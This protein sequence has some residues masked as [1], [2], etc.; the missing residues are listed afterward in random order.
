M[1]CLPFSVFAF[2]VTFHSNFCSLSEA[3]LD[4]VVEPALKETLDM[5]KICL[6]AAEERINATRTKEEAQ[7]IMNNL[8]ALVQRASQQQ[9]HFLWSDIFIF[10]FYVWGNASAICFMQ[11]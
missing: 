7:E 10:H 4:Y 1:A 3:L 5:H 6:D 2:I 8:K 9:V 11:R